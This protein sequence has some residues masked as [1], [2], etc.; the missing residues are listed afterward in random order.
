[1]RENLPVTQLEYD[2]PAT[3]ILVSTTDLQG[4]ITHCNHAFEATSGFSYDELMGQPHNL[5]RHPDM[6][7][8]AY[9]DMWGTIGRGRP[10]TGIVKNRRKNGD[11]YWVQANV[12][13][14]MEDHKP[15]AYMS[16]RF[17]PTRE[18]VQNAEA[19]YARIA[20][21]RAS[22][23]HTFKLHAGN[24]RP[25]GWRDTFGR[26]HRLTL[27]QRLGAALG[28]LGLTLMVPHA[29]DWD[30]ASTLSAQLALLVV[31]GSTLLWWFSHRFAISLA[32]AD[33]F[34]GDLAGCNLTTHLSMQH[35]GPIT[36]LMRRLWQ[37]Q[38]NLRATIGD[39]RE[40]IQR[41]SHMTEDVSRSS[42]ELSSRTEAQAASLEETA[43]AMEQLAGT[44]R[45]TAETALQV[46][47][48]SGVSTEVARRGGGAVQQVGQSMQAIQQSSHKVSD[49]IAVIEGIAF[50]TNILA[51][52]AA[53]EAARAGEQ[54]RGFAVVAA[55]VRSL[56]QRSATAAKEVRELIGAS[57]DQVAH[58]SRQMQDAGH[59]IQE[60]VDSVNRV[61]A[62]I[63]QISSA[64][65]EQSIG[66][67]QV[68]E[69]VSQLDSATQ[70]NASLG[71]ESA[72]SA[73]ALNQ[74]TVTLARAVQVFRMPS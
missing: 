1:M 74:S 53:V 54:G 42:H 41:V 46:S 62:L 37:T 31:G 48:Q 13:P 60:V 32:L 70:Q 47:Q 5:V 6:P 71:E 19:L 36:S 2:F 39:V 44:V 15:K 57:V 30:S 38:M 61:S 18:Q 7:P 25:L 51:L 59:T 10:W 27:T 22:G 17:K 9:A 21:Q 4:R 23:R 3:D 68:N 43:S 69:A 52:N 49:I 50:Q 40:E 72:A 35:I 58:G 66:I 33:E 24:L 55:E 67:A 16:V 45:Q 63:H 11:H 65:H 20:A 29:L 73:E 34:A 12:T 14:I 56:A 8:E 28:L 64:T 26:L